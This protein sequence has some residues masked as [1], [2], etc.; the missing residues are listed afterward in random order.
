M[1]EKIV[2][3]A[4][5][6]IVDRSKAEKVIRAVRPLGVHYEHVM[7]GLGTASSEL[8]GILGLGDTEKAVILGAVDE[9][10]IPAVYAC[11]KQDLGFERA[12]GGVAFTIPSAAVGGPVSLRILAGIYPGMSETSDPLKS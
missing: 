7:L 5:F 9:A 8:L 2:L 10:N 3:K 11:L 12:G 1:E 6:I 4:L